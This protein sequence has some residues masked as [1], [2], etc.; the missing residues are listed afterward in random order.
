MR[1][2]A[3]DFFT[4]I[5][6]YRA[7]LL[8][9]AD[10]SMGESSNRALSEFAILDDRG[11]TPGL[12]ILADMDGDG[13]DLEVTITLVGHDADAAELAPRVCPGRR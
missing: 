12:A 13:I 6:T 11:S 1:L 2:A 7:V 8:S 4:L 9:H 3:F 10:S 5:L